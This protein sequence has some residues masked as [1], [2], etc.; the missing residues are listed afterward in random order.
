MISRLLSLTGGVETAKA[1]VS[2]LSSD[3][4]RVDVCPT[5]SSYP[6]M[7]TTLSRQDTLNPSA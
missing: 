5:T 6:F 3:S 1:G 2:L 7:R 4:H